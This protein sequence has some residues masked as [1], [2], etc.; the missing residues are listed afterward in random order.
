M[1]RYGIYRSE[2]AIILFRHVFEISRINARIKIRSNW[3]NVLLG[4]VGGGSNGRVSKE[5]F[6]KI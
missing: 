6:R 5:G 2:S 3:L 1:K 4:N